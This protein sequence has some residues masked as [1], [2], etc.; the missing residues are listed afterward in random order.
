MYGGALAHHGVVLGHLGGVLA[1]H[2]DVVGHL[3]DVQNR[4]QETLLKFDRFSFRKL[5]QE[6]RKSLKTHY[7]NNTFLL[8]DAFTIRFVFGSMFNGFFSGFRTFGEPD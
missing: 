5:H 8:L 3:G 1:H 7:E 2:G 4:S 6:L